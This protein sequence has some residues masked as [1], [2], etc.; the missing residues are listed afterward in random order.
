MKTVKVSKVRPLNLAS[1]LIVEAKEAVWGIYYIF[2]RNKQTNVMPNELFEY[3]RASISFGVKRDVRR[4]NEI[5]LHISLIETKEENKF[6]VTLSCRSSHDFTKKFQKGMNRFDLGTY[7]NTESDAK[8]L[9]KAISKFESDYQ[10]VSN[11][12]KNELKT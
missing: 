12:W 5:T 1:P 7:E 2:R 4:E 9:R 8:K 11:Y 3:D 10:T 6:K